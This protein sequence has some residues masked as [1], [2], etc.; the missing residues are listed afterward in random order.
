VADSD[1]DPDLIVGEDGQLPPAAIPTWASLADGLLDP[2][3]P[4]N[5]RKTYQA[6]VLDFIEHLKARVTAVEVELARRSRADLRASFHPIAG[7][8]FVE[9]TVKQRTARRSQAR[10]CLTVHHGAIPPAEKV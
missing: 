2:N 8:S 10:A 6:M 5:L 4:E 3:Y 9:L 1:T 7:N